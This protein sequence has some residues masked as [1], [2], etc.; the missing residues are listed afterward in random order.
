MA[1]TQI[2]PDIEKHQHNV[3]SYKGAGAQVY[4]A[5]TRAPVSL[6][7]TDRLPSYGELVASLD[8]LITHHGVP[9]G[10]GS[11]AHQS[12]SISTSDNASH[13]P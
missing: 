13:L 1:R 7:Q 10:A 8:F 5:R 3:C 9:V 12:P 6:T 2:C 4:A 11:G